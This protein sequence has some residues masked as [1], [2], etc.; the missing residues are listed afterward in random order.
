MTVH[1]RLLW[2]EILFTLFGANVT[3]SYIYVNACSNLK[4][5][6]NETKATKSIFV[7]I[8]SWGFARFIKLS[9]YSFSI[10]PEIFTVTVEVCENVRFAS[11]QV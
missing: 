11:F 5:V 3:I 9:A 4:N 7:Y 10:S 8:Y 6:T 1:Q 2:E